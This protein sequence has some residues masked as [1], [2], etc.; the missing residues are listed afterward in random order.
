MAVPLHEKKHW[1]LIPTRHNPRIGVMGQF[2]GEGG[3][4]DFG[5]AFHLLDIEN[6]IALHVRDF[7]LHPRRSCRHARCG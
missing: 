4:V 5:Q 6:R 3:V 1:K 7:V 2:V